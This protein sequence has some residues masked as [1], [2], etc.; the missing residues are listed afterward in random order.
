[1]YGVCMVCVYVCVFV[2][3]TKAGYVLLYQQRDM[4]GG[5]ESSLRGSRQMAPSASGAAGSPDSDMFASNGMNRND[6][7]EMDVN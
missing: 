3:Q 1:M 5:A 2:L 4:A 7:A 6:D